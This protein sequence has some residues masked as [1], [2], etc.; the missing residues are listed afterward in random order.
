LKTFEV[1]WL[2]EGQYFLDAWINIPTFKEKLVEYKIA[3]NGVLS[4]S[5]GDKITSQKV[6]L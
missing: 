3:V 4:V 6:Q 1:E 2:Q 5:I